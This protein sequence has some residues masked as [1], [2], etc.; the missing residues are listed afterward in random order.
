MNT[1]LLY[2]HYSQIWITR[3]HIEPICFVLLENHTKEFLLGSGFR[4][5]C[6]TFSTCISLLRLPR[7][8]STACVLQQ[9]KVIVPQSWRQEVRSILLAKLV[10]SEA[11]FLI[12]HI[13]VAIVSC[14]FTCFSLYVYVLIFSSSENTSYI[15][16]GLTL[17]VIGTSHRHLKGI[18]RE[19]PESG[20]GG[21][22]PPGF[23]SSHM[24]EFKWETLVMLW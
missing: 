23:L 5:K 10:S 24:N 16:L 8:S 13:P 15:G 17:V 19:P 18:T 9:Q 2:S 11:S 22:A 3:N 7:Q 12:L 14:V 20:G 21:L 4:E 1:F 6:L